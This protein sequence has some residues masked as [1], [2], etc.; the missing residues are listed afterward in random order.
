VRI[1]NISKESGNRESGD[2]R[3]IEQRLREERPALTALELDAVKLRTMSSS[4][5]KSPGII[6]RKKGT[7]MKSRL[8][9]VLVLALGVF[10][11]GTGATLAISGTS[12]SGSAGSAQYPQTCHEE[13]QTGAKVK[14]SC[15]PSK[16]CHEEETAGERSAGSCGGETCHGEE[17]SGKRAQGSCDTQGTRQASSGG[18]GGSLPFTG[19]LAIPVLIVGVGLLGAGVAMRL[20]MRSS[21]GGGAY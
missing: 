20:R 15:E 7:F 13:E 9:L 2:F 4:A 14:G 12:G 10:V 19:F 8:A 11:S 6:V 18:G 21:D 3:A 5:R 16:T 17:A 1:R